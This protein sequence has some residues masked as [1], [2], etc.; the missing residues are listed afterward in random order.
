MNGLTEV[1]AWCQQYGLVLQADS[2]GYI[3]IASTAELADLVLLV[4]RSVEPHERQLGKL[5]GYP[6]C[7][8]NFVAALGEANIDWLAPE[9]ANWLFV[10]RFRRIDPTGY[11]K[12]KSLICHLPCS[13]QCRASLNLAEKALDFI[14]ANSED[15]IFEPWLAWIT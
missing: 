15:P 5:L 3:C 1:A 10:G 11:L 13:P 7:C 6:V 8:C 9:I 14:K 12:G 4:D 2:E